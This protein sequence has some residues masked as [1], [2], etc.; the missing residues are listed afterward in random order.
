MKNIEI[1][2]SGCATTNTPRPI[3]EGAAKGMAI[4]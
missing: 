3:E 2:G 4:R 1:L